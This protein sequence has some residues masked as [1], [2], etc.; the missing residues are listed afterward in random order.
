MVEVSDPSASNQ[1]SLE[2]VDPRGFVADE[3]LIPV[4][5]QKQNQ[6]EAPA[7]QRTKVKQDKSRIRIYGK[8]FTCLVDRSTGMILSVEKDNRQ[9][10]SGG[11]WLMA[12]PLTGGGCYPNHNA[13]TPVFNDLCKG[14][15][16][17]GV[18][19]SEEGQDVRL[20]VS[21]SYDGFDGQYDMQCER[22]DPG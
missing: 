13:E 2:F 4:G 19:V 18:E 22:R 12:L 11:P 1:L 9:I 8:N 20:K 14:W 17:T 5:E 15:K 21:G 10:L 6:V 3:Y 16:V 7:R